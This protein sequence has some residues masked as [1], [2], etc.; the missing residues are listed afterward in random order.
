MGLIN[1]L[2]LNEGILINGIIYTKRHFT[3]QGFEYYNERYIRK[4]C[5]RHCAWA[6][7][8]ELLTYSLPRKWP[9]SDF[10]IK[11]VEMSFR[12]YT[13]QTIASDINEDIYEVIGVKENHERTEIEYYFKPGEC[14]FD[15]L[16]YN[17]ILRISFKLYNWSDI[18]AY[19]NSCQTTLLL[20][21]D[22]KFALKARKAYI[23]HRRKINIRDK[24][25]PIYLNGTYWE[26]R[27]CLDDSYLLGAIP[28]NGEITQEIW[29]VDY[30]WID[31]KT[32]LTT[33]SPIK[34]AQYSLRQWCIFPFGGVGLVKVFPVAN[35]RRDY[36]RYWK[37]QKYTMNITLNKREE[38]IRLQYIEAFREKLYM[39]EEDFTPWLKHR[40]R[41]LRYILKKRL[42]YRQKRIRNGKLF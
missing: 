33:T 7:Y 10:W 29:A 18:W 27:I 28:Y 31:Y 36:Y 20:R 23:R 39:L 38:A 24:R 35:K 5:L 19:T 26:Q 1:E 40:N 42:D 17:I 8:R 22:F 21:K 4:Q 11:T 41:R 15:Y 16:P 9:K 2:N 37:R 6:R 25:L 14:I 12:G 13:Y 32:K 34:E 3:T 30:P